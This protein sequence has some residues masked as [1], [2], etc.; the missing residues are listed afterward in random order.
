MTGIADTE[1]KPGDGC[2]IL[3]DDV[4]SIPTGIPMER[5]TGIVKTVEKRMGGYA[6]TAIIK[7]ARAPHHYNNA[8]PALHY[9]VMPQSNDIDNLVAI[10]D[11]LDTR[12]R[13]LEHDHRVEVNALH[14]AIVYAV[15]S[16]P[17]KLAALMARQRQKD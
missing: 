11:R 8:P 7:D 15:N 16:S 13:K 14:G 17:E 6:V 2:W 4:S 9:R 1:L 10:V 5:W 12:I 3:V